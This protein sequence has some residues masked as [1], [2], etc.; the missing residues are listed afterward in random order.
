LDR[1]SQTGWRSWKR[2]AEEI[3]KSGSGIELSKIGTKRG[4]EF[5]M[6]K[7]QGEPEI[8]KES[9]DH[10]KAWSKVHLS[11]LEAWTSKEW[12]FYNKKKDS[13]FLY[14][15]KWTMVAAGKTKEEATENAKDI[16]SRYRN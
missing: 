12:K 9:N 11:V 16:I 15:Y 3:K 5:I 6:Q 13:Y 4:K 8:V 7:I 1:H 14:P 2:K 10:F